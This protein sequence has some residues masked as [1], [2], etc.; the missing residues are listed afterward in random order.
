VG[1]RP[2]GTRNRVIP[3]KSTLAIITIVGIDRF[4]PPTERPINIKII[5]FPVGGSYLLRDRR[6]RPLHML[7]EGFDVFGIHVQYWMPV[8]VVII[9]VAIIFEMR[10][11]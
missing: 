8:A 7:V 5:Y 4:A 1:F 6:K 3:P 9:V 2:A 10:S 11:R